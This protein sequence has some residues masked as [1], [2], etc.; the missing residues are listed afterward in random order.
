[1]KLKI[2]LTSILL[3]LLLFSC[4][5]ESSNPGHPILSFLGGAGND[6]LNGIVSDSGGNLYVTGKSSSSWGTPVRAYTSG[7]DVFAAKIN[8]SGQ[9][10][11]LTFL[12]GS[13]TD[14]AA[15]ICLDSSG[16]IYITGTSGASWGSPNRAYTSGN[17]CFVARLDSTGSLSWNTFL[18]GSGTDTAGG[19]CTSG[20]FLYVCGSSGASWTCG[21][22]TSA[23]SYSSGTD[24]F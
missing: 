13:G 22:L 16:N 10:E 3:S 7:D 23:Q 9:V 19:I 5:K 4:E 6:T 12:G 17:D 15:G 20:N 1:M 24:I 11:W 18:G 21:S 14:S 8:P 2:F